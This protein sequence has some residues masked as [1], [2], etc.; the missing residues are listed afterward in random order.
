MF[1]SFV[2]TGGYVD[3]IA[4]GIV[5]PLKITDLELDNLRR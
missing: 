1:S 4:S 2:H 5:D 3:M